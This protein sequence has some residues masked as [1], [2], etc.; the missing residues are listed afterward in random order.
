MKAIGVL[1][2]LI[3][4]EADQIAPGKGIVL[5]ARG[6][7]AK[8]E[9]K[10]LSQGTGQRVRILLRGDLGDPFRGGQK[11]LAETLKGEGSRLKGKGSGSLLPHQG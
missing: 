5:P 10:Q 4:G 8:Q 2:E 11:G 6:G 1:P 9:A 3:V 7:E